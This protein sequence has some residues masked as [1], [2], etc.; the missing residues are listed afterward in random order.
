MCA[1]DIHGRLEAAK[2]LVS[3]VDQNVVKS[4]DAVVV[5]G[6]IGN[7]QKEDAFYL[8]IRELEKL[9]KPVLYVRGN[10]DVN[11]PSGIVNEDPLVAELESLGPLELKWVTVVGHGS[12]LRPY[13]GALKRPV[14]LVTHYPPFSILDRGK[15]AEA[16]HHSPHTGLPEVNYLVAY[17]KPV[18]HVF[19][20]CH[21]LGGVD[22]RH[23]GVVYVNVARLDRL[24]R[25]G[26]IVGNYALVTIDRNGGVE[27]KWRFVNGEWKKCSRCGRKVHLP[28]EWTMCRRCASRFELGFRK[29]DKNLERVLVTVRSAD[30]EQLVNDNFYVPVHTLRDEDSYNDFVDYLIIKKLKEVVAKGGGKLLPLTKEEVAELYSEGYEGRLPFSE[31]LFSCKEEVVGE[32]VCLLMKLYALDKRVKVLWRVKHGERAL[33][34]AEY[35]LVKEGLV[36]GEFL[37]ELREHGFTPLISSVRNAQEV[38]SSSDSRKV[39]GARGLHV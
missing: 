25:K 18:V 9:G 34:E 12:S 19:G 38:S 26:E 35:V 39:D 4:V 22:V 37:E 23:G 5:A 27:V 15:K 20:H 3:S 29:L 28:S 8:V 33:V 6:D 2:A 17:Y 14:V 7:P 13:K 32:K 21:A 11:A 1:S 31:Y 30:G 16:V 10:W 24:G 36:D